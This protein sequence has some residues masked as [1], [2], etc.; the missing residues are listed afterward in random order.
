MQAFDLSITIHLSSFL[1][2]LCVFFTEKRDFLREEG[3]MVLS[4]NSTP[5]IEFSV[6]V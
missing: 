6:L 4:G 3:V 2:V 5:L 1:C